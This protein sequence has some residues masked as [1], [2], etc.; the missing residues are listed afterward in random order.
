MIIDCHMHMDRLD[1]LGWYD[2]PEKV[3]QAMDLAGIARG[4]VSG[5][6]N[7]PDGLNPEALHYLADA[8][9][10]HADRLIPFVRLD[11]WYGDR[12]LEV[13]ERAVRDLGF[14]GVKLHPVHY[15]LHPHAE[16]TL[17]VLRKASEL[18]VPVLI[19]CSDE[20]MSL[21]LQIELA[22]EAVPEATVILAHMGGYYHYRDAIAVAR[23]QKHVFLDTSEIPFPAAI[24]AAVSELGADRV[25]F[26]S[27]L[28][29]DNPVLEVEKV[30][31][32]GLSSDA[33]RK[34]L[35]ENAARLLG[36][37]L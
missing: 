27:D 8:A 5:Y 10:T 23:R 35:S 13:L 26:G 1:G 21:P 28:P 12:T 18:G 31:L 20:G 4:V 24:K 16:F 37:K 32:A 6:C 29:G 11:P 30:R 3:L 19:H 17:N 2:P 22:V 25:L 34:V 33:E 15:M 14:R 9:R 36:L 7:N